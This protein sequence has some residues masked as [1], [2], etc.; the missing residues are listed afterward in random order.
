[1]VNRLTYRESD[2][3]RGSDTSYAIDAGADPNRPNNRGWTPLHQSG[4]SNQPAAAQVLLDAGAKID[5]CGRGDGGTP[6]VMALFWG[7]REAADVLASR[8]FS[9]G[10]DAPTIPT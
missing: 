9:G 1:M 6:L 3:F 7:H 5:L 4:Y 2:G 10:S 8:V